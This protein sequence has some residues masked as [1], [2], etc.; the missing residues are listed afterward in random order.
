MSGIRYT[1]EQIIG[2]LRRAEV[3][4]SQGKGGERCFALGLRGI[5]ITA[6]ARNMAAWVWIKK[7]L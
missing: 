4:V 1:A 2:Y 7:N 5:R 3:M 6:G